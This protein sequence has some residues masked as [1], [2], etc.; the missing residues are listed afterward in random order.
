MMEAV[1]EHLPNPLE[2]IRAIAS[3]LR[4]GGFFV[5]TTPNMDSGSF[6]LLR[7]RWTPSLAPH[8]HLFLFDATSIKAL[9]LRA[10]LRPVMVGSLHTKL[11]GPLEYAK[12]AQ[13]QGLKGLLWFAMQQ[14]G[15]LYGRLLGA[16]ILLFAIG[17]KD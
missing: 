11:H 16:G 5:L 7:W 17:R 12:L 9:L 13:S 1:I 10:G 4:P 6:R 3:Y 15:N 2:Q 8:A 14:A